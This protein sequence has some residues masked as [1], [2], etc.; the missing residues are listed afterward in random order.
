MDLVDDLVLERPCRLRAEVRRIGPEHDAL[1]TWAAG[2]RHAV[3]GARQVDRAV[4]LCG[5][6]GVVADLLGV[7]VDQ[8]LV[9]IEPVPQVVDVGNEAVGRAFPPAR[10]VGPVRTPAR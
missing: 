7:R 6:A 2:V 5:V 1:G 8:E 9:G 10:D 3:G 4:R